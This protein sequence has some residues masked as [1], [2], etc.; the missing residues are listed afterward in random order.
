MVRT[1][2][3]SHT[4]LPTTDYLNFCM[5]YAVLTRT[6]HCFTNK[7]S[8]ITSDVTALLNRKKRVFKE[9]DLSKMKHVQGELKVKLK[10]AREEY[11]R[12]VEDVATEQRARSVG[13]DEDDDW[14]E[15]EQQLCGGR[16]GQ[17][18]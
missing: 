10:E 13:Y 14:Y 5:D 4:A 1:L 8:W 6:V 3:G 18:Q 16:S 17:G 12:K 9:G 7:M 11:R 2:R 15:E